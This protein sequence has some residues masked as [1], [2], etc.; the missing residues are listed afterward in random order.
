M[1]WLHSGTRLNR[2]VA[3]A[4]RRLRQLAAWLAG[5][6]LIL[7]GA[8]AWAADAAPASAASTS[9]VG[10]TVAASARVLRVVTDENYPP[11]LF[12][13]GDGQIEGYL[14][15]YW[16]LWQRRSQVR[17]ELIATDWATAQRTLLEGGAD[18]IDM[19]FRTPLRE[20][21]YD[22]SVPY[23]DLPVDIFTHVDISGI[24]SVSAL[25]GFQVGVQEGDACIDR[26]T[27]AGITTLRTYANYEELISAAQ[28]SEIKVF[29]LD[30]APANFYLY[31][32]GANQAFKKAFE[33]YVG[34]FHRGVRKGDQATLALV[35]QGMRA[36]RPEEDAALRRKW[37][38][39]PLGA[40]PSLPR[41]FWWTLAVLGVAAALL[42]LWV[43]LLRREV[44]ARTSDLQHTLDALAKAHAETEAARHNL[45]ATLAAIPDMLFEFDPSGR[46]IDVFAGSSPELLVGERSRLIGQRVEEVLPARAAWTVMDAIA[47][48]LKN[49][50]DSG[51]SI[52]LTIG[53]SEHWFELSAALKAGDG[54]ATRVL[55]LSRDVTARRAAEAALI[56]AREAEAQVERDRQVRALFDAAPVAMA[57]L[58]GQA[59]ARVNHC[60][61][62]WFGY[63]EGELRTLDDWWPR[64]YPDPT[65]RAQVQQEWHAAVEANLAGQGRVEPK[66]YQVHTRDGRC[67]SL[68]IGGQVVADGLV[69]AMSD[70]TP[71]KRAKEAAEAANAAKSAFLATMSHEIRTPLNAIIGMTL[72]ALQTELTPRQRDYLR[73]VQG[74][75][76]LLLGTINDVLDYSKIE[77]GRLELDRHEF[78]LEELLATVGVQLSERANS[79][80]LE[81]VIDLAP[82][83]P[84]RLIGDQVR[85][86]QILLN[87][88]GNALKFTEQG[89]ACI[90]ARVQQ[91]DGEAL[92]LRCE[93]EDSGI[94]LTAEQ[95]GRLFERFQQADSSITRRFGGTGLGLA[96]SKHL[97]EAMGGEIGVRSQPGQGST[98]WFTV[99]LGVGTP[100]IA[101]WTRAAALKGK[102]ALVVDDH[103]TA[104]EVLQD[105]LNQMGLEA[106]ACPD[107]LQA[108]GEVTAA[109]AD[110]QPFDV[111][112]LDWQ[113]P[114]IDGI[115]LADL[116]RAQGCVHP[117]ALVLVTGFDHAE[118]L[119][120]AKAAGIQRVLAKPVTASVMYDALALVFDSA[121][122]MTPST[123][124]GEGLGEAAAL[125]GCRALV[126]E[127]NE[128]NRQVAAEL[129]AA[130]GLA[131]D[132]AENGAV[133]L[134][135][136]GQQ[137]Y[138]VVLMDMQMP[139]MDGLSATRALRKRPEGANLP[140]LAMTANAMLSDREH[141]LEAGMNDH[142]AKPIDPADLTA[143]L[144][145]W[146]RRGT[147]AQPS[148]TLSAPPP[149]RLAPATPPEAAHSGPDAPAAAAPA[150][151]DREAGLRLTGGNA[152]LYRSLLA[153]FGEAQADTAAQLQA[154]RLAQDSVLARRIA[155]SLKGSAAQLGAPALAAAASRLEQAI[156]DGQ[157]DEQLDP[158]VEALGLEQTRL[159]AQL[160]Q[161]RDTTG[162]N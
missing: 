109:E 66:E 70:V 32:A 89:G 129:L 110:A 6:L 3:P 33:F 157:P 127:D 94:G 156:V 54:Q 37:I 159:L 50:R 58:R 143:K 28:R 96:I 133:A 35:E 97:A 59:I 99:R 20:A 160:A 119:P 36:I 123:S 38:G 39:T 131:V 9:A 152:A 84:R 74:A 71:Q 126:V 43:V 106:Q 146:V 61:V 47:A 148:P 95:Q 40:Q 72:L 145:R 22:F 13:N 62:D 67:L 87:L 31:R 151:L 7:A 42:L 48:T 113:M 2:H 137:T 136:V 141:C 14:V 108:L 30:E 153:R 34:Q 150:V 138:D 85:L 27:E 86:G 57:Y 17:V 103:A 112:L 149:P 91:R 12:R 25:K 115:E 83:V 154:A 52:C 90:R 60:F 101:P 78:D 11:Y 139:V 130:L 140:I 117:P 142:I 93:V 124:H 118:L 92:L 45:S 116:I 10:A 75:G 77:A 80:G 98:F 81:L 122:R 18:V 26:L 104:R 82:D 5:L 55:M 147:T 64:A 24:R 69:V 114:N 68:L 158:L 23:A 121:A 46:Y 44:A 132:T 135:R 16:Q 15:D 65:Y 53:R 155:H 111:V 144:L 105:L 162:Q 19:I 107:A 63:Q 120:A 88:G 125:K 8:V 41:E 79:R 29:C 4:R 49:G 134:E 161:D 128:L 1:A 56:R 21:N 73:K 100:V 51:R 102:R 76:Q